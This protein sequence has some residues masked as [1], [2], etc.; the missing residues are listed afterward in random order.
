[1][2]KKVIIKY[3]CRYYELH[4]YFRGV[5]YS[6]AYSF[7][8]DVRGMHVIFLQL[9]V[10]YIA[11]VEILFSLTY[12]I[13]IATFSQHLCHDVYRFTRFH[14]YPLNFNEIMIAREI[15]TECLT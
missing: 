1:M 2:Y 8:Y 15:P 10:L 6:E 13:L 9:Y 7:R 11:N 4:F 14:Q 5:R 3:I 12:L